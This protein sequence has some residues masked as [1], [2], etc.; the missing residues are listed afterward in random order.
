[1]ARSDLQ[2]VPLKHCSEYG[3]CARLAQ[4]RPATLGEAVR[5][6]TE[7]FDDAAE[8]GEWPALPLWLYDS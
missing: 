6:I 2:L 4:K 1:M 7:R 8:H 3:L 5:N